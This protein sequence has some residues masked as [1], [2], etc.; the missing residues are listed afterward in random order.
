VF[1]VLSERPA[2]GSTAPLRSCRFGRLNA[3]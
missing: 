1:I 2:S 3:Q